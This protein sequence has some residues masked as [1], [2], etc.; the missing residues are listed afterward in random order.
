VLGGQ[1]NKG[2]GVFITCLLKCDQM[3][4]VFNQLIISDSAGKYP[5]SIIKFIY[6]KISSGFASISSHM[7]GRD[8]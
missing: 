6:T 1:I 5:E 4:T 3:S 8:L 7:V 2:F